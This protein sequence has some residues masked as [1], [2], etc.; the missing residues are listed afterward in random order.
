MENRRLNTSQ[1]LMAGIVNQ[2]VP[3]T[4]VP[5]N[6]DTFEAYGDQMPTPEALIAALEADQLLNV[7]EYYGVVYGWKQA[8]SVYR[9]TLLQYRAVTD[10]PTFT[11]A[12]ELAEWFTDTVKGVVG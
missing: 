12:A 4:D 6:R 3:V 11:T 9:G 7:S 10:N 2:P 5:Q 1:V 8:A